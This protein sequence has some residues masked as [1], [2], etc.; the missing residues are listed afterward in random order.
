VDTVGSDHP[1]RNKIEY[2]N[3]M[4]GKPAYPEVKMEVNR[5]MEYLLL[6]NNN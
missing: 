1:H 3:T 2:V 4:C 6:F 5:Y